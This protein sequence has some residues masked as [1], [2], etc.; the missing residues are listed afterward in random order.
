[1]RIGMIIMAMTEI[2]AKKPAFVGSRPHFSQSIAGN[3]NVAK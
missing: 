2:P 3:I 1:M